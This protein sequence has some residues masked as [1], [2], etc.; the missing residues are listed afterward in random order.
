MG[1]IPLP[2]QTGGPHGPRGKELPDDTQE[3]LS[4]LSAPMWLN[5]TECEGTGSLRSLDPEEEARDI[6]DTCYR[7]GGT[8][9]WAIT[10]DEMEE[11]YAQLIAERRDL[12]L[13]R[14]NIT[15]FGLETALGQTLVENHTGTPYDF[16]RSAYE[17]CRETLS[18][19]D[20]DPQYYEGTD[21]QGEII[22]LRDFFKRHLRPEDR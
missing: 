13:Y 21:A 4:E 3:Q 10:I 19:M 14:D 16:V 12:T 20:R 5:C 17:S 9:R 15:G 6:Q 7:C 2:K 1:R 8:G 11:L 18:E 22:S